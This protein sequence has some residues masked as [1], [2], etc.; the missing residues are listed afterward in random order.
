MP[1][2]VT[3]I[4]QVTLYVSARETTDWAKR[5]PCS[6]L[7]GKRLMAQFD[8][9]GLIDVTIDGR[10]GDCDAVEFNAITSD[11]LRDRLAT[12]HPAYFAAVG[13]FG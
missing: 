12:D 3:S 7:R 11:F 9:G 10:Y 1:R 5:W 2:L 13:Q 6:Q 4:N 8:S